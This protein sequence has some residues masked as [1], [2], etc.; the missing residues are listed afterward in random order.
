M[1][2]GNGVDLVAMKSAH[3]LTAAAAAADIASGNG[4]EAPH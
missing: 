1:T 2:T 4:I 3:F